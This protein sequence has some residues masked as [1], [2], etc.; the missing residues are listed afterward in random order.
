MEKYFKDIDKQI[1]FNKGKNIFL[2]DK[3][4]QFRFIDDTIKVLSEI[5]ELDAAA[6]KVLTGYATDKALE[7]FYRVNQYYTFNAGAINDLRK[8]YADLFSAIR[9]R[10]ES[11]ESISKNHYE[12]IRQWLAASNPF[13]KQLYSTTEPAIEPVAC[14][15]YTAELQVHILNLDIHTIM[16]PVLDIGC[17]RHGNLV[18]YLSGKGIN[19]SGIDRFPFSENNLVNADWLEYDYGLKKWG[20]IVSNLGFSNHFKHHHL[21]TDGN[22]IAYGGK[23]MDIL[24]SLKPGGSFHYAPDLP[25]IECYLDKKQYSVDKFDTG[26]TDFKTT[27]ITRLK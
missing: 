12:N 14:A 6:E 10:Q 23:Y 21:R 7:E 19:V 20:T 25:F 11:T 13:A 16:E 8:I 27:M 2:D 4:L 24:K 3:H 9:D 17:G 18:K 22:Y 15:E 26:E 5:S 1:S